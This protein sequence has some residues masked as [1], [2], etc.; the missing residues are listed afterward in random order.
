[1][2]DT[3]RFALVTLLAVPAAFLSM[4][5]KTPPAHRE[6]R[7]ERGGYV[8][9]TGDCDDYYSALESTANLPEPDMACLVASHPEDGY[10]PWGMG[11]LDCRGSTGDP[12]IAAKCR[13]SPARR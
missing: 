12:D 2:N 7:F 1:M 6:V 9:E 8:V 3:I 10:D 5:N 11:T 4:A 13:Q